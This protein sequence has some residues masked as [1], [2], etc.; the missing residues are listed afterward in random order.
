MGVGM[1]VESWGMLGAGTAALVAGLVVA[2]GRLQAVVGAEKVLV[3]GPVLEAAALATFA[4]EH[5]TAARQLMQIV[6]KWLPGPLFWTYL[7]GV[8]LLAAAVSLIAWRCVRWSAALLALL[9]VIIVATMDLPNVS[10]GLHD[11]IFWTLTV[12]E[13]CFASG[14]L[15]LAGSVW[16]SGSGIGRG[17]MAAGRRF[18]AMVMVFYGIEHFLFPRNVV[19]VPLEKMTPAWIPA[20][21]AIAYFVGVVLVAAGAG[22]LL[23][24]AVRVAA[25]VC[26]IVLLLVTIFFYVPIFVTEIHTELAVEGLNYIFDTMLFT[27]TVMLAGRAEPGIR[28][29]GIGNRE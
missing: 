24:C 11:R 4:A 16:P 12:R 14:A 1:T 9:F 10:Q 19:G 8:A 7:V 6:P 20:A 3:L 29:Q 13:L 28:E 27:A 25:A 23:G 22:L 18:V 26:G 2:R 21:P 5:F 15:V 17:L